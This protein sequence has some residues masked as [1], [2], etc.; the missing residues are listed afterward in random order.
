MAQCR[1]SI[2]LVKV[3]TLARDQVNAPHVAIGVAFGSE[4][5]ARREG[6]VDVDEVNAAVRQ[7]PQLFKTVAAVDHPRVEQR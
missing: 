4:A 6:R 5:Q 7:A 3:W 2:C 1:G